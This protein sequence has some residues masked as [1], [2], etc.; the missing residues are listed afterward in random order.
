MT[1]R[2]PAAPTWIGLTA[3]DETTFSLQWLDHADNE[4]G[5]HIADDRRHRISAPAR[6]GPRRDGRQL[7]R[8]QAR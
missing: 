8:A 2:P 7:A 3:G 1:F 4:A 5:F 6:P